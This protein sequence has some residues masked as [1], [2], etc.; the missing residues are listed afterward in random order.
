MVSVV[1][2]VALNR[3]KALL[4]KAVEHAN[5]TKTY[6]ER[7]VEIRELL[8]E[9]KNYTDQSTTKSQQA[10][11]MNEINRRLLRTVLVRHRTHN[12]ICNILRKL[13]LINIHDV[14]LFTYP[15]DQH[16]YATIVY[17]PVVQRR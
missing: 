2:V 9:L 8:R 3:A 16:Y 11:N 4:D 13:V 12:I 1:A 7:L 6:F 5:R 17:F 14:C 10:M 15:C